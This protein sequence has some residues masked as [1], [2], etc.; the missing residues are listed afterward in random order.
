M[1]KTYQKLSAYL[2]RCHHHN[3]GFTLLSVLLS[4]TIFLVVVPY[5]S[6]T[7]LHFSKIEKYSL[8]EE[9]SMTTFFHFLQR[10]LYQ[11]ENVDAT[12]KTLLMQ[13]DVNELIVIDQYES[14][15]R[16]RVNFTGHEILLFNVESIFFQKE[17]IKLEVQVK[18]LEGNH[19]ERTFYILPSPGEEK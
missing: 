9:I 3:K 11:S 10:E 1:K 6:Q 15:I 7:L 13:N 4:L 17:D 18:M 5:L 16:R 14:A 2:S 19:Y 12:S 8:E